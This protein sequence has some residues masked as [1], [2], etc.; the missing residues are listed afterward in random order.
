MTVDLK[1]SDKEAVLLH[2]ALICFQNHLNEIFQVKADRLPE[3]ST[4][5]DEQ[6]A[7]LIRHLG[8]RDVIAELIKLRIK[9][10][11][12]DLTQADN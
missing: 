8:R 4:G 1:L 9:D 6:D 3:K 5:F 12:V 11:G 7:Y 10:S 2:N